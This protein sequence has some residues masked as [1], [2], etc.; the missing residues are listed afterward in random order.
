[1][2]W[3]LL[4]LPPLWNPRHV[5]LLH[6]CSDADRNAGRLHS[7]QVADRQSDASFSTLGS[8]AR[9]RAL[10]SPSLQ[11]DRGLPGQS[12]CPIGHGDSIS[13]GIPL[14]GDAD[15]QASSERTQSRR[16]SSITRWAAPRGWDFSQPPQSVYRLANSTAGTSSMRCWE[17]RAGIFREGLHAVLIPAGLVLLVR[18]V[19]LGGN[20]LFLGV[21]HPRLLDPG[22]SAWPQRA[23]FSRL[24]RPSCSS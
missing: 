1:M 17:T 8:R 19:C 16:I 21:R 18:V 15:C 13:L 2:N 22:R 3:A 9:L 5:S 4:H 12:A 7:H 20:L 23:R 10:F 11:S 14:A 6:S 24:A